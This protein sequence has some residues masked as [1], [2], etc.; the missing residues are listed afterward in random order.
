MNKFITLSLIAMSI[1]IG[2]CVLD[3]KPS[4]AQ[5]NI[6][7]TAT[8]PI[9]NFTQLFSSDKQYQNCDLGPNSCFPLVDVLYQDPSTIALKSSYIDTIWKAVSTIKKDGYKIDGITSYA[10][11]EV[12]S[13]SGKTINLLVVMSK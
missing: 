4:N 13:D 1:C 7:N 12:G 5:Q 6:T 11:N 9:T 8:N 2:L 3:M 10:V